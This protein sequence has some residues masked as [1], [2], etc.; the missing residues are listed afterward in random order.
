MG[1]QGK[2]F[3]VSADG[4]FVLRSRVC[5]LGCQP[6]AQLG[7]ESPAREEPENTAI[8][9][10]GGLR[11]QARGPPDRELAGPRLF[12]LGA[13]RSR[14]G[15]QLG[16]DATAPQFALDRRC[17]EAAAALRLGCEHLR[18]TLI[19]LE[20]R[21]GEPIEDLCDRFTGEAFAPQATFDFRPRA[22]AVREENE[23][24]RVCALQ[25]LLGRKL[26]W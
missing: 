19:A 2:R 4:P 7:I 13:L 14:L 11:R 8:S 21:F 25:R 18:E 10:T 26:R 24:R 15:R 22:F 23:G 1:G 16:I 20:A 12:V 3:S 17:S 9:D 6:P 5:H